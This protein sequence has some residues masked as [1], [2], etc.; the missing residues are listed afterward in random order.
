M[1]YHGTNTWLMDWPGGTLVIDPGCDDPAH[2]D[3]VLAEAKNGV[4]HILLT[5]THHDHLGGAEALARRTGA[6]VAGHHRS[7]HPRFQAPLGLGEGDRIGSLVV[8]DT[9]GHAMDHL[10]FATEDGILFTGDHVMGWSTSVV[11]PP[12]TGDLSLFIANLERVR[13]RGDRLMLS[14]HGPAIERPHAL[15]QSL[16]DH[17]AAREASIASVLTREPLPFEAVFARAYRNLRPDLHAPARA[18]LLSHLIKLEADGRAMHDA[19]GWR[20]LG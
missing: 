9:P 16:L 2:L 7:A 15:V 13:D 5:H 11:P 14:A 12:P 10:C 4:S 19:Q 8:L 3:A 17:R 18:N 6:A 20:S 1:T